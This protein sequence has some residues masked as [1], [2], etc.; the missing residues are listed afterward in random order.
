[1]KV[2]LTS[3]QARILG[4]LLEKEMTTPDY[5]PMSLNSLTAACNQ[6]SNRDPVM[7]L[8][9]S[10][11]QGSLNKLLDMNLAGR[12]SD[13]GARV[14]KYGHSLT[15]TL[16]RPNEYKRAEL[17]VLGELLLRG[18]QTPGELRSHASRMCPF[19]DLEA[20]LNVLTGLAGRDVPDV[21]ELARQPGR[22][23]A[24]F[25]CTWVELDEAAISMPAV[26][27]GERRN[28]AGYDARISALEAQVADLAE[29][30]KTLQERLGA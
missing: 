10:E 30:L 15:G 18:P 8:S 2:E 3:Q 23:E 20:V 6:K 29:Q 22:R 28:V 5:Y 19:S 11:V 14:V 1:M 24:R 4:C 27:E 7:N 13:P 21:V 25:A 12:R 9:E 17:A 26:E 16:T